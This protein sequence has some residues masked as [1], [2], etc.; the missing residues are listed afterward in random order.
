M[1]EREAILTIK[2]FMGWV[3]VNYNLKLISYSLGPV[4]VRDHSQGISTAKRGKFKPLRVVR[5]FD[6]YSRIFLNAIIGLA[7]TTKTFP[8]ASLMVKVSRNGKFTEGLRLQFSEL[9]LIN[10]SLL[11]SDFK[12]PALTEE[13]EF[14][15]KEAT[16]VFDSN[17]WV[18]PGDF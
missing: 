14:V 18:P 12:A 9:E 5:E 8:D 15:F 2:G 13:I 11:P 3:I 4:P 1:A 10:Y 7:G 17:L 6:R 16:Y